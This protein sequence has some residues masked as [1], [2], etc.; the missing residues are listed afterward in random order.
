L[1]VVESCAAGTPVVLV[2]G[3]GNA[4]LEL[5]ED[6]VNGKVAESV[7]PEALG[8][9]I[10]DV[11]SAGE[12]LRKTTYEWF[13]VASRTRTVHAAAEQILVRLVDAVGDVR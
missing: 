3:D 1:V 9:A 13:T 7:A 2:A 12:P 4:A 8:A 6:G 5:V 11:V 10:V